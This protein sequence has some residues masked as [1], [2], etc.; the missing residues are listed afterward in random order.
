[1]VYTIEFMFSIVATSCLY[2][3]YINTRNTHNLP[4][5]P[6]APRNTITCG[7]EKYQH[8]SHYY[9]LVRDSA[10]SYNVICSDYFGNSKINLIEDQM[11]HECCN[12]FLFLASNGQFHK[13]FKVIT[14]M[15]RSYYD[16]INIKFPNGHIAYLASVSNNFPHRKPRQAPEH[17]IPQRNADV[18]L[19]QNTLVLSG[20][21]KFWTR[22]D[23]SV[24][25]SC[26]SSRSK[27]ELLREEKEEEE[28]R[29]RRED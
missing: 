15:V 25:S 23:E 2:H 27:S 10:I 26:Y 18:K 17:I 6:K 1:M 4:H 13:A 28:E 19:H 21:E 8:F 3:M 24:K 11:Y 20:L 22:M 16:T 7:T 12:Q 29:N 5:Q 14:V 9:K